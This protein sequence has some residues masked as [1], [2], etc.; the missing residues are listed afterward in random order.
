MF[1]CREC[2]FLYI[3]FLWF[4]CL[5]FQ[6]FLIYIYIYIYIISFFVCWGFCLFLDKKIISCFAWNFVRLSVCF[7]YFCIHTV[8]DDG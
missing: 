3:F 5:F 4:C 1:L 8:M 7:F 2:L 6:G